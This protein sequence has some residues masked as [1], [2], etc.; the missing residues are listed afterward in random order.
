[1]EDTLL[2]CT[3][4]V[5]QLLPAPLRHLIAAKLTSYIDGDTQ[6]LLLGDLNALKPEGR[7]E[8]WVRSVS[9]AMAAAPQLASSL[10]EQVTTFNIAI[11]R[12]REAHGVT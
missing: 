7:Y 2:R 10:L 6:N 1:M 4:L 3:Q 5:A 9:R 11:L 12:L 8:D